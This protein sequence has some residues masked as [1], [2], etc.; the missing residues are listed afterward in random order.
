MQYI[1]LSTDF[2][3]YADEFGAAFDLL[4]ST[5][6]QRSTSYEE[7]ERDYEGHSVD[8]AEGWAY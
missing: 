3:E 5:K 4:Y 2:G 7:T 1:D 8:E 6:K